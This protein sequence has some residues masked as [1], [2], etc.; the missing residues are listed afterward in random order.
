MASGK[1]GQHAIEL[2]IGAFGNSVARQSTAAQ[3]AA[4]DSS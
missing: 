1:I 2:G 4:Q 3:P